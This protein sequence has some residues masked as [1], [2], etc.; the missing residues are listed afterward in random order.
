MKSPKQAAIWT[1]EVLTAE[2]LDFLRGL[3]PGPVSSPHFHMWH[4]S[5]VDEDEYVSDA[6]DAAPRFADFE[7]PL[8][9]FGHTHLQGG[10]LSRYGRIERI[11]QVAK[12]QREAIIYMKPDT[13]YMVNPGSVGQPRDRDP[14]A[15]YALYDS[16]SRT[17]RLR[18]VDYPVGCAAKAIRD[19]HLPEVLAATAVRRVL[20]SFSLE[21][22]RCAREAR[23]PKFRS[24]GSRSKKAR[25]FTAAAFPITPNQAP[26]LL[27][28]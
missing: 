4:G 2:Q 25:S 23:L 22:V 15:A 18:R 20:K 16:E 9:F 6:Q 7:L 11:P 14:R 5:P 28:A 12:R 3:T 1:R 21:P 19:A 13:L 17:V 26:C 27:P 8:A 10:F 24:E